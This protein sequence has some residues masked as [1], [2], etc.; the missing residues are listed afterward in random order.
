[1]ERDEWIDEWNMQNISYWNTL[2]KDEIEIQIYNNVVDFLDINKHSWDD[3][4]VR[5]E[6][7]EN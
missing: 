7:P 6:Y 1:M 3:L 2:R 5:L 4:V